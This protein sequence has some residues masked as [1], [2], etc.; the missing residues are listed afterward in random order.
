MGH[1]IPVIRELID[2]DLSSIA[3]KNWTL[4]TGSDDFHAARGAA[5]LAAVQS[6]K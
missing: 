6:K 3:K 1:L 5:R 4:M 2:K